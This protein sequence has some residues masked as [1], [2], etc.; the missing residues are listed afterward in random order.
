MP[1]TYQATLIALLSSSR[2]ALAIEHITENL[3]PASYRADRDKLSVVMLQD[4][5][6]IGIHHEEGYFE[7]MFYINPNNMNDTEL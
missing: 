1:F 2:A 6:V 4:E 7:G 5:V 3:L